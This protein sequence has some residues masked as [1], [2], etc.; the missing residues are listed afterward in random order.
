MS[1]LKVGFVGSGKMATAIA[2]GLIKSGKVLRN[3]APDVAASCP[4][5]DSHLLEPMR[6][7]GC[8]TMF[9]N[10]QLVGESDVIVLVIISLSYL[11]IT[12]LVIHNYCV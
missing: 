8:R 10:K 5:F 6:K 2:S 9:C 1:G 3:G 11:G 7:L 4:Q 12:Q